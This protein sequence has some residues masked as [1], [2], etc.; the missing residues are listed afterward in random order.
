MSKRYF[1]IEEKER[2]ISDLANS[3]TELVRLHGGN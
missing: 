2:I 1:G 3:C